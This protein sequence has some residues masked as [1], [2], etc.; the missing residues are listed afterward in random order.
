LLKGSKDAEQIKKANYGAF[1]AQ[2]EISKNAK[3]KPP[4]DAASLSQG[5]PGLQRK[6]G[7]CLFLLQTIKDLPKVY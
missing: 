4:P 3:F 2:K 5:M 7:I 1:Q 6:R